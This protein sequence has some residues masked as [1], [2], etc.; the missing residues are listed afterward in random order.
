MTGTTMDTNLTNAELRERFEKVYACGHSNLRI[1]ADA[2]EDRPFIVRGKGS[3]LWDADGKEYIDY[4]LAYGPSFLGYCHPEIVRA[5]EDFLRDDRPTCAG[6]GSFHSPDDVELGERFVQHV[7]CAEKIKLSVTGTDAVQAAIRVARAYT[8]RP[9]FIRF[10]GQ[11]HGW[12]DNT[13]SGVLDP[14]PEGRPFAIDGT[15]EDHLYTEGKAEGAVEQSFLLPYNEI[16]VLEDTLKRYG[17][18]VALIHFE[19]YVTNHYCAA[20]KPGYLERVRELCDEYG[21]VMSFD[22]V[23]TGFRLAMGGAQQYLGVTPDIA[24]YGKA[25][26][27]GLPLSALAGRAEILDLFGEGRVLGPGTFNAFP[28]GICAAL[29]NIKILERDDCAIYERVGT[30]TQR[31]MDGMREI[32]KRRGIRARVQGTTGVFYTLLGVDPDRV[33]YTDE[34]VEGGSGTRNFEF[35]LGLR[36]EGIS[37][38]LGARWF[39]SAAITDEDV[40]RTLEISD[41]VLAN[42]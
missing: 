17:E 11:Y 29:A 37:I 16:E 4:L 14:N 23:I 39:V 32:M 13:L 28:L 42:L 8:G 26:G 38:G 18:E 12:A 10:G 24:T 36:E 15:D 21:I 2:L 20:P 6:A 40:D 34:D 5:M 27:G 22:E 7:P 19:P 41:K 35:Y 25:L 30:T 3:H 9:R 1:K 33:I 31:L